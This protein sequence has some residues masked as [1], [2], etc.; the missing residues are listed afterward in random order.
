MVSLIALLSA[1]KLCPDWL[2]VSCLMETRPA[3]GLRARGLF[4]LSTVALTSPTEKILT[5]RALLDH[6]PQCS[7]TPAIIPE[8]GGFLWLHLAVDREQP[9][10]GLQD[11][12]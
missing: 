1:G 3:V 10:R 4:D 5:H 11:Q 12:L 8:P 9:P 7:Q 2:G 6:L